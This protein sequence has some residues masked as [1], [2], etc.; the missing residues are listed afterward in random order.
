M[1]VL[2]WSHFSPL[3]IQCSI[4]HKQF[5]SSSS[6]FFFF[7]VEMPLHSWNNQLWLFSALNS[8][9]SSMSWIMLWR[10]NGISCLGPHQKLQFLS[11]M[12][13]QKL[14]EAWICSLVMWWGWPRGS[15]AKPVLSAVWVF[16][17]EKPGES[18]VGGKQQS[19]KVTY[20]C[21]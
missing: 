12:F 17:G 20:F 4:L 21:P 8:F 6:S 9:S 1:K 10:G 19:P 13:S 5:L 2:R 11:W 18:Q 7:A 3:T 14:L 16:A 15:R